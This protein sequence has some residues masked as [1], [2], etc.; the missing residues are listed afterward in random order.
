[1]SNIISFPEP[2][3]FSYIA[4]DH[5]EPEIVGVQG[6]RISMQFAPNLHDFL[7][8]DSWVT[9]EELIALV[10]VTGLYDDIKWSD[11]QC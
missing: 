6:A 10:L 2:K 9:R 11:E 8:G 3:D 5:N 7:M 4:G 1:M